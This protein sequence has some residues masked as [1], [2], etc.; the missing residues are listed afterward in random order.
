MSRRCW[1]SLASGPRNSHDCE[2]QARLRARGDDVRDRAVRDHPPAAE[3]EDLRAQL[4]D[5]MQEVRALADVCV[6]QTGMVN[7]VVV[8]AYFS[9]NRAPASSRPNPSHAR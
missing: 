9:N 7:G 6:N 1:R 5:Q 8:A 4:L 3:D 2:R